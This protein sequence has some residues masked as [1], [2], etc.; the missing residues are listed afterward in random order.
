M[1]FLGKVAR[2]FLVSCDRGRNNSPLGAELHP[3]LEMAPRP[4]WKGLEHPETLGSVPAHGRGWDEMIWKVPFPP[5]PVWDS[6]EP[7]C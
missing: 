1:V 7:L 4:G 5:K 6:M 2:K 3:K